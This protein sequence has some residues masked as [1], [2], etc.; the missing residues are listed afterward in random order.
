MI[1]RI[2]IRNYRGIVLR[3]V[4]PGPGGLVARGK[5]GA[6]KTSLLRAVSAALEGKDIGP[7]AIHQGADK[8][9]IVVDI[10]N[11]SIRRAI[12][13]KGSQ[14]TVKT[15]DGDTKSKPQAFLSALFGSSIDPCALFLAKPKERVAIVQAAIP[16]TVTEDEIRSQWAPDLPRGTDC[17]GH[18]LDA[19]ARVRDWYYE[20]RRDA[21]SVAKNARSEAHLRA[22][23]VVQPAPDAPFLPTAEKMLRDARTRLADLEGMRRAADAHADRSAGLREKI[24]KLRATAATRYAADDVDERRA[25]VDVTKARIARLEEQLREARAALVTDEDALRTALEQNKAADAA[26]QQAAEIETMLADTAPEAVSDALLDQ[27]KAEIVV[28]E[29]AYAAAH[30]ADRAAVAAQRATEAEARAGAAEEEAARLD[31]IVKA[32]TEDAPRAIVAKVGGIE[33][34]S[35]DGDDVALDGVRFDG[36]CGAEQVMFAVDIAKRANAKGRVLVVDGLERL[37]P[38][39]ERVLIEHATRDGWQLFATAVSGDALVDE[40]IGREADAAE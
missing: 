33:G 34:L 31:R 9:E 27:A 22:A 24:V 21:N 35:I 19:I 28:A 5:N 26:E 14:L 37:D 23:D 11:L 25:T 13:A 12:T 40:P 18:G 1:T 39:Q 4:T 7:D 30:T 17:S 2:A 15:V 20:K 38:E 8:A 10:D 3:E 32:L 16:C 29:Q 6:G 36:L